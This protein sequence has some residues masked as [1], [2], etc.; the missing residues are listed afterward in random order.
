M[1]AVTS[2]EK[3]P[4]ANDSVFNSFAVEHDRLS[5]EC[6]PK[7]FRARMDAIMGWPCEMTLWGSITF[8][9]PSARL[10][11]AQI[12][13][14]T[15]TNRNLPREGPGKPRLYRKARN[16]VTACGLARRTNLLPGSG[17][18]AIVKRPE[19]LT[20]GDQ[21][22]AYGAT[23]S[24]ADGGRDYTKAPSSIRLRRPGSS[25]GQYFYAKALSDGRGIHRT[26]HRLYLVHHRSRRRLSSG[27]PG[28]NV[29]DSGGYLTTDQSRT[30]K[31]K[32]V[33]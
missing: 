24:A 20:V 3:P 8:G 28:L 18:T 30:R 17:G 19:W 15:I 22:N 12:A 14:V 11:T 7:L 4:C 5:A 1:I 25:P 16:K 31:P 26:L 33:I 2:T 13:L 9:A 6:S 29:L 21:N 32:R 10:W 27:R 23:T